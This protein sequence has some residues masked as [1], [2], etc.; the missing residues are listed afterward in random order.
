[1]DKSFQIRPINRRAVISLLLITGSCLAFAALMWSIRA[2]QPAAMIFACL[3]TLGLCLLF[4]WFGL[5]QSWSSVTVGSQKLVLRLPMY[6]RTISLERIIP[7]SL[8]RVN[9]AD[10]QASQ[11]AWRTNGLSVPGY[12]LG[13]FRTRGSE[14]ALAAVTG[15]DAI[16]FRTKDDYTVLVSV[17][18]SES[19]LDEVRAAL[20]NRA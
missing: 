16:R 11:L 4:A 15:N 2:I 8:A 9:V 1:M 13:W 6:G 17:A 10:D 14:K 5:A 20:G 12:N 7:G 19:F 18:D 3:T